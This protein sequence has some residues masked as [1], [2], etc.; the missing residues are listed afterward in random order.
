MRVVFLDIDGVLNTLETSPSLGWIIQR[1][2]DG[3]EARF[4]ERLESVCRRGEAKIVLSSSWRT[5]LP[6]HGHDVAA[7]LRD[8]GID[9]EL[10]GVTPREPWRR[11]EQI[12]AWLAEHPE[13]QR[14]VV[15]DDNDDM[16]AL[17][18]ERVVITESTQGLTWADA[19]RAVLIL[20]GRLEEAWP[21]GRP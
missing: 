20:Q 12:A 14:Y 10:V 5:F 17:P 3:I 9:A 2:R 1:P 16:E 13:V 18:P 4:V 19:D 21:E 11:G 6:R 7:V 8:A 15:L